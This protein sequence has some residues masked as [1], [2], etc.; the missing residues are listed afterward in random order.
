MQVNASGYGQF[1]TIDISIIRN[2]RTYFINPTTSSPTHWYGQCLSRVTSYHPNSFKITVACVLTGFYSL[3]LLPI[4]DAVAIF[5]S[6]IVWTCL[7]GYF[8][9]KEHTHIIDF[10][11]IPVTL[12]GVLFIAKPPFIFGG[13]DYTHRFGIIE[14]NLRFFTADHKLSRERHLLGFGSAFACAVLIGLMYLVLRKVGSDIHYTVM[15]FYYS[16]VGVISLGS[17]V[18]MTSGFSIPCL[19]TKFSKACFV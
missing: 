12:C 14:T 8:Y 17:I 9:L 6:S 10:C 7:V 18:L 19:V 4:G 2:T 11:M 16:L 15:S 5:I 1:V 3:T 13:S